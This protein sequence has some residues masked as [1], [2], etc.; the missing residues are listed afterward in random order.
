MRDWKWFEGL[1][2]SFLCWV[3]EPDSYASTYPAGYDCGDHRR[4]RERYATKVRQLV[5]WEKT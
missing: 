3:T 5:K 4:N 2:V 1:E